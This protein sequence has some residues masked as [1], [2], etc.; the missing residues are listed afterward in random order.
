M[1][2]V[3]IGVMGGTFDPP[4]NGHLAMAR[5]V[6]SRLGLQSVIFIPAG[7]PWLKSEMPVSPAADRYEMVKLAI[8]TYPY[9]RPS[10]IEIDRSGP[11]YTVDTLIQLRSELSSDSELLFLVGWDSL[12]QLPDWYQPWR[13][14]GL[15]TLVALPRPGYAPDL[16][17]L[18]ARI[19][20]ISGHIIMLD[21]PTMAV[22]ATEVRE[23][24]AQGADISKLV[25]DRVADYIRDNRL[26]R[27]D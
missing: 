18:E 27:Q 12:A 13:L 11:S 7:Q 15:C 3:K 25:P 8:S 21:I 6:R 24:A 26:Y 10:S 4:H 23:R 2:L 1:G 19:P 17:A 9:F 22:S 5:E 14:I 20:G 16:A